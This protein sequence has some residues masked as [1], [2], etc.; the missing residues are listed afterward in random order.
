MIEIEAQVIDDSSQEQDQQNLIERAQVS[1]VS[2]VTNLNS[3]VVLSQLDSIESQQIDMADQAQQNVINQHQNDQVL[4]LQSNSQFIVDQ[5]QR[6]ID[7]QQQQTSQ[8]IDESFDDYMEDLLNNDQEV[9]EQSNNVQNILSQEILKKILPKQKNKKHYTQFGFEN[10]SRNFQLDDESVLFINQSKTL[11]KTKT[12]SKQYQKNK[13]YY[14]QKRQ[15]IDLD[16]SSDEELNQEFDVLEQRSFQ[17]NIP[18]SNISFGEE[19]QDTIL[20]EEN[21]QPNT[22][23]ITDGNEI[24]EF[25]TPVDNLNTNKQFNPDNEDEIEL[26][27]N[28]D[29]EDSILLQNKTCKL[30]YEKNP[31]LLRA[32]CSHNGCYECWNKWLKNHSHCPF[33]R[34]D[35]SDDVYFL[36]QCGLFS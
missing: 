24:Q 31:R 3:Q 10:I 33:C 12:L 11:N 5:L 18:L 16:K 17:P 7:A 2:N 1:L 8:N 27:N 13:R 23:K 22:N 15:Y 26:L 19:N 9:P 25:Q 32:P 35:I 20:L 21:K 36:N 6:E 29:L 4:A 30:C 34:Q 28:I 14:C